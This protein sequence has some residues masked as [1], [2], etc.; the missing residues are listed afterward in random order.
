MSVYRT[1]GPLVVISGFEHN[2]GV[3]VSHVDPVS[4]AEQHGLKVNSAK[5]MSVQYMFIPP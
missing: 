1:I 2:I 3:F 5:N 4:Q